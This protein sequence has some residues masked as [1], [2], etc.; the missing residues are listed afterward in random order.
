MEA[1][2][3]KDEET[4]ISPP[5]CTHMCTEHE[6]MH[7]KHGHAG[8]WCMLLEHEILHSHAPR[9]CVVHIEH[10]QKRAQTDFCYFLVEN[11]GFWAKLQVKTLP[12]N[13]IPLIQNYSFITNQ[14]KRKASTKRFQGR[15]FSPH[16][17]SLGYV[18][19]FCNLSLIT[20]CN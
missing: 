10:W 15:S 16:S 13:I 1:N 2:T 19:F 7:P 9:A 5:D 3:Q 20:R 6:T 17:E 12:I 11:P 18:L 4:C 8:A 14:F